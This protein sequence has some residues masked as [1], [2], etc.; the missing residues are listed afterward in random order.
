MYLH[1]HA[2]QA[3]QLLA[4]YKPPMPMHLFLGSFFKA[5]KKFGSK[6]RK[7]IA[8]MVYA[9]LRLGFK[10]N[11]SEEYVLDA[12]EI[13]QQ[14]K[15]IYALDKS[16]KYDD[17]L[18]EHLSST[19]GKDY[20]GLQLSDGI[21]AKTFFTKMLVKPFVFIKWQ[22]ASPPPKIA[23]A[24]LH[25]EHTIAFD[26]DIKLQELLPIESDYIIQ[27]ATSQKICADFAIEDGAEVWDCCCA[28]G[29]KSLGVLQQ[30]KRAILTA[31]DVRPQILK[32]Y[33]DRLA[34]YGK[35]AKQ[36]YQID[37]Q[38]E[39]EIVRAL[40]HQTFEHI[41]CDVPCSGSGTWARTP[42]QYFFAERSQLDAFPKLQFAIT[43]NVSSKI[44]PGGTLHYITCSAFKQENEG[45]V[46][47][48]LASDNTLRL[49]S[50][51]VYDGLAL[52]SDYMFYAKLVKAL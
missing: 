20:L 1:R 35:R 13:L 36:I 14:A 3:V 16:I 7:S 27:D 40:G 12:Y 19:I 10:E 22:T 28:S 30:A 11:I 37:L 4:N 6:D 43:K 17:A 29:G 32:N 18:L 2:A 39:S 25:N 24:V 42:E 34:K 26:A 33:K 51:Q 49:Q 41:I 5:N 23:N 52:N 50:M 31:S 21:D 8:N 47:Q 9:V 44:K 45:I 15:Q 48:I 46:Q 38:N